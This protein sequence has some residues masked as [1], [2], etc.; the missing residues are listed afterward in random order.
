LKN[1]LSILMWYMTFWY[2]KLFHPILISEVFRL[3]RNIVVQED[4]TFLK[5]MQNCSNR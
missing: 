2:F 4:E 1:T 3:A 5:W